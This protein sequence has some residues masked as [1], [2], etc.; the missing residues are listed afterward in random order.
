VRSPVTRLYRHPLFA[1]V[2][3]GYLLT[4]LLGVFLFAPHNDEGLYTH[5]AQLMA[6]DWDRYKYMSMDGRMFGEYKDPLQYWVAARTVDWWRNPLIGVRLWSL[7]W[8]LCGLVFAQLLVARVWDHRVALVFGALIV[9]SEHYWYFDSI[10]LAEPYVYGL[11]SLFLYSIYELV[12]NR[13]FRGWSWGCTAVAALAAMWLA[14]ET[15]IVWVGLGAVMPLLARTAATPSRRDSAEAGPSLWPSCAG[16]AVVVVAA[17]AIHEAVL[18]ARFAAVRAGRSATHLVTLADL[19]SVPIRLWAENAWFYFGSVLGSDWPLLHWPLLAWTAGALCF[20]GRKD[21]RYWA[22]YALFVLSFAPAILLQNLRFARHFGIGLYFWYLPLSI[23][24]TWTLDRLP[25]S[26]RRLVGAGLAI[27][28]LAWKTVHG[29]VPLARWQLTDYAMVETAAGWPN[30][31]GIFPLLDR[32]QELPPGLLLVDPQWGHPGTAV[33]VFAPRYFPA[34]RIASLTSDLVARVDL[35]LAR[36]SP[37]YVVYDSGRPDRPWLDALVRHLPLRCTYID[38]QFRNRVLP[39]TR[40]A[41]CEVEAL[42]AQ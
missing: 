32:I 29:F 13:G 25:A 33:A 28:L 23:C 36:G 4:R 38:K 26:R 42:R 35:E 6:R 17:W 3:A 41:L 9:L 2:L 18:P 22:A 8:G 19:R 5:Y 1:A 40:L 39:D 37:V 12:R 24:A 27:A 34:M 15:A 20:I 14:K 10:G 30:G 21:R 11:G 7:I 31:A 16:L